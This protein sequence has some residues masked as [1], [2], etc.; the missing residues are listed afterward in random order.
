[1][2]NIK[3]HLRLLCGKH[4]KLIW[5]LD[6]IMSPTRPVW[7]RKDREQHHKSHRVKVKSCCKGL[8]TR[9]P[10]VDQKQLLPKLCM[11]FAHQPIALDSSALL[12]TG[13][14]QNECESSIS[15]SSSVPNPDRG[16]DG[17]G[18]RLLWLARI[19]GFEGLLAP[20]RSL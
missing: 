12:D 10:I 6:A 14:G 7:S 18:G 4:Q 11:A 19:T 20:S 16:G 8:A 5:D 9:K 2:V 17:G 3:T 13:A 1:M 15:S